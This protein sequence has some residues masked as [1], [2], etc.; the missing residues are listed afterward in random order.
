VKGLFFIM[1]KA[2]PLMTNG[3]SIILNTSFVS[4]KERSSNLIVAAATAAMRSDG[5]GLWT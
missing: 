3:A 4:N 2:L 1:Q 5:P